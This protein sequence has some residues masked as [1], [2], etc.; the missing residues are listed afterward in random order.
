MS[1]DED[2]FNSYGLDAD[3]LAKCKVLERRVLTTK[4]RRE[5]EHFVKVPLEWAR[6]ICSAAGEGAL[7]LAIWLRYRSWK[8]GSNT[9][10]L[11]RD[12]LEALGL[13]RWT[14]GRALRKLEEAGV[15]TVQRQHGRAPVVSLLDPPPVDETGK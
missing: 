7:Y 3:T 13:S 14:Q 10:K 6:R 11:T 8:T 5:R 4:Q 2:D 9:V 1:K 12:P 15:V